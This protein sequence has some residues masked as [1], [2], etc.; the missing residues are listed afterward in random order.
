MKKC[1]KKIT[2]VVLVSLSFLNI[3]SLDDDF[4]VRTQSPGY[5]VQ[6]K[7][8][9]LYLKP[10]ASNTHF[11]AEAFPLPVLSPDWQI[12]DIAKKYHFGFDLFLSSQIHSVNG[13][14]FANW[15]YFKNCNRTAFVIN[16]NNM[17]G[18]FLK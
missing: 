5:T 3:Y 8:T 12:Y 9:A 4:L 17:V 7:C 16:S 13:L 14:L 15:Q 2:Y 18:P 11:A 6:A 10:G 1:N